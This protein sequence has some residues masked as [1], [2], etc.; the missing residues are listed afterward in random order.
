VAG[1]AAEDAWSGGLR[2]EGAIAARLA[3]R[4]CEEHMCGPETGLGVGLATAGGV[5]P[6]ER[7]TDLDRLEHSDGDPPSNT[8]RQVFDH[9]LTSMLSDR[10]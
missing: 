1:A 8:P 7:W 4:G 9:N 5:V 3:R 10:C 2:E 6:R